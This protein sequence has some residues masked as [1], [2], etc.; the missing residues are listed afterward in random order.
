MLSFTLT[1]KTRPPRVELFVVLEIGIKHLLNEGQDSVYIGI[2]RM[3]KKPRL[4]GL[5]LMELP[6]SS[7]M[8][9]AWFLGL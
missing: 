5:M 4:H 6:I 3:F 7:S 9:M 1:E 2:G 8:E